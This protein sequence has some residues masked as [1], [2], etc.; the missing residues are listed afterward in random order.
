[1]AVFSLTLVGLSILSCVAFWY[2]RRYER[3]Q[4]QVIQCVQRIE[5]L[6][7]GINKYRRQNHGYFPTRLDD[8]LLGGFVL[9][10]DLVCP[11]T[12]HTPATG[13]TPEE[14]AKSLSSGQH[15]SYVYTGAGRMSEPPSGSI[16][17]YEPLTNHKQWG[18]ACMFFYY[19][20]GDGMV[21]IVPKRAAAGLI[22]E[23]E[24]GHNPPRDQTESRH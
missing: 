8:L 2:N 15:V 7:A 24:S 17:I 10:S 12:D 14:L 13:S 19:H 5:A 3:N 6:Q 9:P 18:T 22:A 1:M 23:V 11:A 4:A 20:E 21:D 16:L